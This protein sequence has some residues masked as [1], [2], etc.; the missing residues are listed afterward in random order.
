MIDPK[1]LDAGDIVWI[2]LGSPTGHEQ[3]G[4]RPAFVVSPLPYNSSSS[5]LLVCPIT[6]SDRYWP[7]KVPLNGVSGLT[8]FV[9]A[10][11]VR[12][13]DPVQRVRRVAG[14]ASAETTAEVRARLIPIIGNAEP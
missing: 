7:F 3:G 11:Q 2:D 8:G 13:I 14:R 4:R 9:V 1:S 5:L 6:R 10:D 12:A